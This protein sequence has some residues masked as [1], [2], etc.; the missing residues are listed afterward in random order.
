MPL[1][2]DAISSIHVARTGGA[3]IGSLEASFSDGRLQARATTDITGTLWLTP[4][5][6]LRAVKIELQALKVEPGKRGTT[7]Q[8]LCHDTRP[9]EIV[10]ADAVYHGGR[11]IGDDRL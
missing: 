3:D 11:E 5:I 1:R 6:P 10:V 8:A 7:P 4:R 9:K 2:R